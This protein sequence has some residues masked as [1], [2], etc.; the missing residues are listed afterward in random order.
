MHKNH[1]NRYSGYVFV[2]SAVIAL[3]VGGCG[4]GG[5]GGGASAN[6]RAASGASVAFGDLSGDTDPDA[7]GTIIV[8]YILY[9]AVAGRL[10][11]AIEFS[12]DGGE[13]YQTCT[14]DISEL[15]GGSPHPTEGLNGLAASPSGEIHYFSWD[16]DAPSN[17]PGQNL[18]GVKLRITIAGGD[19]FPSP[20]FTVLNDRGDLTPPQLADF[21]AVAV[22]NGLNDILTM[23]FNEPIMQ[24]DGENLANFA[25]EQPLGQQ[26]VLPAETSISYDP[27]TMTTTIVCDQSG[28]PD[29]RYGVPAQITVS[30]VRDLN[31]NVIDSPGDGVAVV[32]VGG[33][34][35]LLP[36]DKPDL[37]AAF[38]HGT[39]AP[40]AGETLALLFNEDVDLES[41]PIF[42]ASDV[43]FWTPG[44]TIGTNGSIS[45]SVSVE[46]PRI[47]EIELGQNPV[48]T[49]GSSR[50]NIPAA[51]D[52][53]IDLAGNKPYLP[54]SPGV[55]DYVVIARL[56]SDDPIIDLLTVCG[57]PAILNG[58]GAAG[59]TIWTPVTAFEIDLQYHDVGGSGVNPQ[60][61]EIRSSVA[62]SYDGGTV[63]AGDDL[64]PY[65]V[66]NDADDA[67]ASYS[68][69]ETM[70]FPTGAVTLTAAVDDFI[71]NSSAEVSYSFEAIVPTNG[72]RPFETTVNPSQVWK[73]I[74][75][76]D[77]Y[78]ISATG[79]YNI[80]VTATMVSNGVSDFDEDLL[81]FGLN[82]ESPIPVTGTAYDSNE[83]IRS[84]VIDGVETELSDV[85]FAGAN[86]EFTHAEGAYFP[87]NSPQV[88]YGSHTESLISI[89]GDSDIMA[90]GCAFIDRGNRC[91]DNDVL[92]KGSYPY[93]PGTNLGIFTTRI[94]IFEVN[95]SQYSLFRLTYD[96]FISGR[97]TPVG[98]GGDDQ[99]ILMDIAGTGPQVGGALAV[100]RDAIL[101]AVD[102]LSR[103]IAVVS[104]HEM[105]HST[106]LAVNNAPPD[107][108]HGGNPSHF[109]GSDSNHISLTSTSLFSLPDMNIMR[110]TTCFWY[111]NAAGTR[112]NNLNK[113]YLEE[114]A[115]YNP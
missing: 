49:T 3:F 91:Q 90:L 18:N 37:V 22:E 71:G 113:A 98:E 27:V 12:V 38:Y 109:P 52:A 85:I 93:N 20:Y 100:R 82:C 86:M 88:W 73:L 21:T 33:D 95:Q 97:G 17:I 31:G 99:D 7:D 36:D 46:N 72:Q 47:L 63:A 59:G 103:Y 70:T 2:F 105:G 75:G 39:G 34:G 10:N 77:L 14:V 110:P 43:E 25:L 55:D 41:G 61:M 83:F 68:V 60:S 45:I 112:F 89:G 40:Q 65:L 1:L 11:I 23:V 13:V 15:L 28:A 30:G 50:I 26:L 6:L 51:N 48:F 102:K 35:A 104:A 67:S 9:S 56:E 115:F 81:L 29:L 64:V 62:V 96:D 79:T 106:G 87:G 24:V 44:E 92:H 101:D 8:E 66:L 84:L 42:N 5:G 107:G 19:S 69:P 76:R 80:L 94:F 16:S 111:A 53:I 114:K 74:Y 32:A 54:A 57:I 78:T 4:G 58:Q 108:L